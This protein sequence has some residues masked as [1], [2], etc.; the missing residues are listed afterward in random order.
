MLVPVCLAAFLYNGI[1]DVQV[2]DIW[3]EGPD[4]KSGCLV[5]GGEMGQV[6]QQPEVITVS[7]THLDVYKRQVRDIVKLINGLLHT[8]FY[9]CINPII[10]VQ[11]T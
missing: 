4:H 9:L 11:H 2:G 7:Y 6:H 3:A 10:I 8:L 5:C 1:A